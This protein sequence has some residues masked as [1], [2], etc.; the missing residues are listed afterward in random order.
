VRD[1]Q[2]IQAMSNNAVPSAPLALTNEGKEIRVES[3]GSMELKNRHVRLIR[4]DA[5]ECIATASIEG[6]AVD[7]I[8]HLNSYAVKERVNCSRVARSCYKDSRIEYLHKS[9]SP[10]QNADTFMKLGELI[11]TREGCPK[12]DCYPR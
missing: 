8:K 2:I 9:V 5:D 4:K 3:R 1:H 6:I 12:I 11:H 10:K 7:Q